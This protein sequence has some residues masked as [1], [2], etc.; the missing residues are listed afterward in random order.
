[1]V[2]SGH[3]WSSIKQYT[4]SEIGAFLKAVTAIDSRKRR[5]RLSYDWMAHNL[6]QKSLKS[7]LADMEKE[8]PL[9]RIAGT[10]K[11][12]DPKFINSEW[13]RL[14]RLQKGVR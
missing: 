13:K 10:K 12:E 5:E 11:A 14:M 4:L 3:T 1:M 7:V 6:T 2:A 8:D 9:R